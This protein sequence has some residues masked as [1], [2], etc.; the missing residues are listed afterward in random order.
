[1]K[2]A[3]TQQRMFVHIYCHYCEPTSPNFRVQ[4]PYFLLVI[5]VNAHGITHVSVIISLVCKCPA[6][7]PPIEHKTN[8]TY[9][10][11][12]FLRFRSHRCHRS[13]IRSAVPALYPPNF[14]SISAANLLKSIICHKNRIYI[15]LPFLPIS[16]F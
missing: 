10:R 11:H 9:Q 4:Q 12:E 16:F 3:Y 8:R 6:Y 7:R 13:Q 5:A 1:M 2:A 14:Y 15:P